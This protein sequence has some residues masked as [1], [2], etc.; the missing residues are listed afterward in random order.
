[1][2]DR[3][4]HSHWTNEEK[5]AAKVRREFAVCIEANDLWIVKSRAREFEENGRKGGRG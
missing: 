4:A 5:S 1:M 2:I 3:E